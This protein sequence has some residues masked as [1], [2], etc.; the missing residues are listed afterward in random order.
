[1]AS[2]TTRRA[3]NL[4]HGRV[5]PMVNELAKQV[6]LTWHC[7]EGHHHDLNAEQSM[8]LLDEQTTQ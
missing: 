1:M 5:R 4:L 6:T 7:P 8:A 2:E 3:Q